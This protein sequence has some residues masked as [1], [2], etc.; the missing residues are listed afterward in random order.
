MPHPR[1]LSGRKILPREL[2]DLGTRE[3]STLL[4][5]MRKLR[6]EDDKNLSV[7]FFEEAEHTLRCQ[8]IFEQ[9]AE[10]AQITFE[11]KE[12]REFC[13][14]RF[15][16][17]EI[18]AKSHQLLPKEEKANEPE[19]EKSSSSDASLLRNHIPNLAQE[20]Q[21]M[22]LSEL[23]AMDPHAQPRIHINETFKPPLA[24]RLC[25]RT[26]TQHMKTYY[27]RTTFILPSGSSSSSSS[28]SSR[29]VS[30]FQ[31]FHHIPFEWNW[32]YNYL[33]HENTGELEI[34]RDPQQRGQ[35]RYRCETRLIVGETTGTSEKWCGTYLEA[36]EWHEECIRR[37]ERR[38]CEFELESAPTLELMLCLGFVC[39]IGFM[40]MSMVNCWKELVV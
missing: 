39:V 30:F 10:Q 22:I 33:F 29:T 6:E 9:G 5:T 36:K 19:H 16:Q 40:A 21:D 15:V 38:K 8:R 31:E 37:Y 11:S 18:E 12:E 24:L 25:R 28:S 34:S 13:F 1:S 7:R 27:T 2:F 23:F 14:R 3:H 32:G 20:L 35:K 26:R 4:T 17:R